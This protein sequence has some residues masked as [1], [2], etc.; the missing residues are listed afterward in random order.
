[1]FGE[2]A[3][4]KS[5]RADSEG[6]GVTVDNSGN[7]QA[8]VDLDPTLPSSLLLSLH[9]CIMHQRALG[10]CEGTFHWEGPVPLGSLQV[11]QCRALNWE[12]AQ[13]IFLS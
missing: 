8:G 9:S 7:T 5:G 11:I 2:S 10:P 6:C 1:M 4:R 3:G 12:G 13:Q